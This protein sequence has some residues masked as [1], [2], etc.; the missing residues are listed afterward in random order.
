MNKITSN[1]FLKNTNLLTKANKEGLSAK[2]PI[3]RR[4]QKIGWLQKLILLFEFTFTRMS[5]EKK[6]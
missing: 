2:C 4:T 1:Y 3:G 5:I 6:K